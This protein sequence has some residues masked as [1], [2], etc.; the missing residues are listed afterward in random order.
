MNGTD[1]ILISFCIPTYNRAELVRRSVMNILEI[2]SAQIEVVVVDNDS[3]D[4]TENAVRSIG[5]DRISYYRNPTNIGGVLNLIQ[6]IKRAKGEWLFFLSDEDTVN[7]KNMEG[8]IEFLS[9]GDYSEI[10]VLM[11]NVRNSD[12]SYYFK[13]DDKKFLKG[14]ESVT[15]IGFSHHYMSGLMINKKFINAQQLDDYTLSDGIYP[16]TNIYTRAC[17]NGGAVTKNIDLCTIG[18]FEGHIS[19]AVKPSDQFYFHPINRLEQFKVFVKLADEIIVDLELKIKMFE[20]LYFRYLE[21]S[22]FLYE[23]VLKTESLRNHFGVDKETKNDLENK[24]DFQTEMNRFTSN[25]KTFLNEIIDDP[26]VRTRLQGSI[27][28]KMFRFRMKRI[29]WLIPEP[30]KKML[31][32]IYRKLKS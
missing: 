18:G 8:V 11:G 14:D 29:F 31:R 7:V 9:T 21:A 20:L 10:A 5:D 2:D 13:Y 30:L 32:T 4:G 3:P 26:G 1:R 17:I 15:K 6:T 23:H 27:S 25:A 24:Y 19:H 22:T 12:G 16:H 28:D